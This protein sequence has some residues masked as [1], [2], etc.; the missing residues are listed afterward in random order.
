MIIAITLHGAH[1]D[2]YSVFTEPQFVTNRQVCTA[3]VQ[4]KHHTIQFNHMTWRNS[5]A[6][7]LDRVEIVLIFSLLTETSDVWRKGGSW[8]AQRKTLTTYSRNCLILRPITQAPNK[9]QACI[10]GRLSCQENYWYSYQICFLFA[11]DNN[12]PLRWWWKN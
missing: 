9:T 12:N 8:N 5:S 10:A 7:D 3:S 2:F 4:F 6:T 1:A 11:T